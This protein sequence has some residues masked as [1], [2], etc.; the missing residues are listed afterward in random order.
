MQ[1]LICFDLDG[2]LVDACEWHRIAFN[3]ALEEFSINSIPIDEHYKIYNGLP[4]VKKLELLGITDNTLVKLINKRKQEITIQ[5]ISNLTLDIQKVN[6]LKKLKQNN[7]LIACVTNS[8]R[9]TTEIMLKNTGQFEYF[10]FVITNQDVRSPKPNS[11]GY[12]KAMVLANCLPENTW[13]V[14]DSPKGITSATNTG[15]NVIQV[16]DAT[17]VTVETIFKHIPL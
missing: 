8:I 16:K 5:L 17:Q 15:A 2:V 4:T 13:I 14:E 3:Q 6:L 7:F 12:V 11:E 10:D 9:E 1:K